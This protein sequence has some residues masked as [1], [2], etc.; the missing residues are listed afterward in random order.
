MISFPLPWRKITPLHR[1]MGTRAIR[2]LYQASVTKPI[3]ATPQT[4]NFRYDASTGMDRIIGFTM[5]IMS[6]NA[7]CEFV[8]QELNT[9]WFLDYSLPGTTAAFISGIIETLPD[10]VNLEF[11]WSVAQTVQCYVSFQNVDAV[12]V[13]LTV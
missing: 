3:A 8:I 6:G 4:V 11:Y 1:S 10:E 7:A 12:P 2:Y 5:S 13:S 9:G